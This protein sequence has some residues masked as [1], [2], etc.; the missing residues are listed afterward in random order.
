MRCI[1][2]ISR[3]SILPATL[4]AL[5]GC[6]ARAPLPSGPPPEYET[7]RA[8]DPEKNIDTIGPGDDD[9]LPPLPAPAAGAPADD[10]AQGDGGAAGAADADSD[11]ET[12][13]EPGAAESSDAP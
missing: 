8:Y 4:V 13:T 10:G 2:A 7:P 5:A 9:G 6:P 1:S 3:L 12:P 11:A